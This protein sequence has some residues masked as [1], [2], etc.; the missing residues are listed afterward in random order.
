[1]H[2]PHH[3][4]LREDTAEFKA[5]SRI[6]VKCASSILY[7]MLVVES[8]ESFQEEICKTLSSSF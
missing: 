3:L 5:Q 2:P 7:F 4:I 6:E 1:M 8:E